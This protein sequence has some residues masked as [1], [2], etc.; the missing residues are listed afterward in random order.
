M[1]IML[2]L[3]VLMVGV[4]G[5]AAAVAQSSGQSSA[6]TGQPA[7]ADPDTLPVFVVK[8]KPWLAITE[9]VGLNLLIW[10]FNRYIREGGTNPGFRVGSESWEENQLNGF[11]W[12]DNS[13][14]T[15]QFAHPY[16]GSLYFNAAR[17]NG[18][19]YWGSI[20]F[21]FAGSFMWEYFMETHHP[22]I[23]D[24]VA[25]SVGGTA[26]GESLHRLSAMIWDNTATGGSRFWS[27]L[28]G[29]IVNPV[30]GLNR[31]ISGEAFNVYA[32]PADRLPSK[33]TASYEV[34]LRVTGDERVWESD[35]TRVYMEADFVY[36]DPFA[37]D[38]EKPFDYFDFSIQLNFKDKSGIGRLGIKGLLFATPL[39][40]SETSTHLIGAFQ[41][42]EYINNWAFEFGGQSIS[43]SYLSNI[44]M[45]RSKLTTEF[46]ALGVILGGTASDYESFTGRSYDYGP[47]VGFKFV[48]TL[49]RQG[50][51][52]FTLVH[53]NYWIYVLNG[54][55]AT[56]FVAMT[57]MR[58]DLP[59][60]K[61]F[62]AGFEYDLYHAE[63]SYTDFPDVSQRTPE[64]R[65]FLSWILY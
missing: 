21:A 14:T 7:T 31:M 15:N 60:Q 17:S 55:E 48:S 33:L 63:R 27:E 24:W 29:F 20:P 32:N 34:G 36:G 3:L 8:Q 59:I 38:R 40:E 54:N 43:A 4:L 11:E 50:R 57:R 18:Y 30:G 65:A 44:E 58:L 6:T 26:V 41:H 62:G 61:F 25:T 47:G 35:T 56:H 45:G 22:A 13:F 42:F 37:G 12:D 2:A 52:F 46:H 23:N 53:R 28:G 51:P 16:H 39:S 19:G 1:S 5:P 9:T 64:F 10:S 49:F